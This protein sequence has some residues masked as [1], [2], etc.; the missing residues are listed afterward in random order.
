MTPGR[1]STICE[2]RKEL[3]CTGIQ[4]TSRYVVAGYRINLAD[5]LEILV[6]KRS[7]IFS[8]C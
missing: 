3:L 4:P 8:L 2:P 5:G 7:V 6:Y 1:E